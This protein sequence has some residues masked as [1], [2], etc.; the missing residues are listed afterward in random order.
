MLDEHGDDT[1]QP[2]ANGEVRFLCRRWR[3][4][5]AVAAATT[6]AAAALPELDVG[7]EELDDQGADPLLQQEAELLLLRG[8][9][10]GD[11]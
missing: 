9:E 4:G 3:G 10:S 1:Q 2:H 7:G 11:Q 8:G 6:A 5:A